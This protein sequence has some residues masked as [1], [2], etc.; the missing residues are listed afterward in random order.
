M[1]RGRTRKCHR[2]S[3]FFASR[4]APCGFKR[5]IEIGER[6]AGAIKEGAT[7]VREFNAARH[8]AKQLYLDVLLDRF[9]EAAKWRLRYAKTLG[10]AGDVPFF[11]D[12]DDVA[13]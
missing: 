1:E 7:G 4:R 6:R 8:A 11:G 2:D 5:A 10:R 9:D 3:T 12:R 13:K